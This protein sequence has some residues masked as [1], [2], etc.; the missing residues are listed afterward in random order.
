MSGSVGKP[1][2]PAVLLIHVSFL[3]SYLLAKRIPVDFRAGCRRRNRSGQS[4]FVSRANH[5]GNPF[6]ALAGVGSSYRKWPEP[7]P[8][9]E[10]QR[11]RDRLLVG[12]RMRGGSIRLL[13]TVEAQFVSEPPFAIP[14]RAQRS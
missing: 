3:L 7:A 10:T 9:G 6:L 5:R 4:E 14:S 1:T 11:S 12:M 2:F 8:L 13:D